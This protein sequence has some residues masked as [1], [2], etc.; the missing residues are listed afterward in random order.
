MLL[1][2]A[3][4]LLPG[5]L[6]VWGRPVDEKCHTRPKLSNDPDPD[7]P[8]LCAVIGQGVFAGSNHELI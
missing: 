3:A 1:S 5:F 8:D 2:P 6:C 7:S 4:F